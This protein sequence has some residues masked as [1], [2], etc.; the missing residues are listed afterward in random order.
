MDAMGRTV[1]FLDEI[2]KGLAG[3]QSSGQL[4]SGV[5]AGVGS[6]FLKWMSDRKPGVAYVVATCNDISQLPPE[7]TRSGRF[8]AT[9]W[10]DLP[11]AEERD[12]IWRI[13]ERK[14]I[15]TPTTHENP[16]P[17][18]RDWTGAEIHSCCRTAVMLGCDLVK[19]GTYIIPMAK[20]MA[21]KIEAL[22][23]WAKG[24]AIPASKAA[25]TLSG[26]RL[27]L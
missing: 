13:Y 5:K 27:A 8:D 25:A 6:A 10:L 15:A 20:T 11:T 16:R 4:D 12:V 26:R 9:F 18:D 21:E 24:R 19:A 2:E 22:R 17:D 23:T 3:V 7:Y 14:Y 1:V